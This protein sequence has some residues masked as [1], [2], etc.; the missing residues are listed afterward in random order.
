M[1]VFNVLAGTGL[2]IDPKKSKIH[3]AVHNGE[4]DP[5]DVFFAGRFKAWQESQ[6]RL[7]FRH[8]RIVSLIKMQKAEDEIVRLLKDVTT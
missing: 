6:K 3:L 2:V 1:N 5:L 8:E 4:E 7:N